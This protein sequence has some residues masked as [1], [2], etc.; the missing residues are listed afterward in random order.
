VTFARE[1][2]LGEREV[3]WAQ[4]RRFCRATGREAPSP[5]IDLRPGGGGVHEAGPEH[6]VFNVS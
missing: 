6:P 3:T 1:Y 2:S 5:V 4:Y